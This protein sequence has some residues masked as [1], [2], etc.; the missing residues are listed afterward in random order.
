M[1]YAAGLLNI[2]VDCTE[3]MRAG[4]AG[5]EEALATSAALTILYETFPKNFTA[6]DASCSILSATCATRSRRRV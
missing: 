2:N 5:D 3:L 4:E 1:E 6:K